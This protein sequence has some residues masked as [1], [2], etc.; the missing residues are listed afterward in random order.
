MKNLNFFFLLV[1]SLVVFPVSSFSF[2]DPFLVSTAT[3]TYFSIKDSGNVG[4]GTNAPSVILDVSA[5][6][7]AN[8]RETIAR[9][10]VS[11][12]A[13]S[14]ISIENSSVIDRAFLPTFS[15]YNGDDNRYGIKFFGK[16][17]DW[18]YN[19]DYYPAMV[20]EGVR[21]DGTTPLSVVPIVSFTS[22]HLAKLT[23]WY[24]GRTK[25]GG[26]DDLDVAG[27]GTTRPTTMLDVVG[28]GSH[29]LM[30][31][32]DETNVRFIVKENGNV[33]IGT[34]SPSQ[35]LSVSGNVLADSYLEYSPFYIGDALS[36]ISRIRPESGSVS[37][38]WVSVDHDTLPDG[39]VYRE[40]IVVPAVY[41]SSCDSSSKEEFSIENSEGFISDDFSVSC[42]S[43]LV[44]ATSTYDFVGRDLGRSVQFNL[45][46]IQQ[47]LER[48]EF[49]E[50]RV[51]ILENE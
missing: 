44:S 35:S 5:V 10:G 15:G 2:S 29:D 39:L 13:K 27:G 32:I 30:S 51:R 48:L 34:T 46:A 47:L 16:V 28:V 38:D 23:T 31:L 22:E 18:L 50:E 7:Q 1:I 41:S 17:A 8:T 24:D 12:A 19:G 43:D 9:F 42:S 14:Y 20:F 6:A 4:I 33:G 40:P 3:S 37:G 26:T 25:I 49:L 21:R 45:R 36:L 11:D